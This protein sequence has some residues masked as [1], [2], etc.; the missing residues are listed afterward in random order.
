ML[1]VNAP[2]RLTVL[3]T[4]SVT[5]TENPSPRSNT[6][7]GLMPVVF[8]TTMLVAPISA[9]ETTCVDAITP[10]LPVTAVTCAPVDI[11]VPLNGEPTGGGAPVNPIVSLP[12]AVVSEVVIVP[13]LPAENTVKDGLP[14]DDP[15]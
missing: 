8:T 1:A 7:P 9:F 3:P 4:T 2:P 14:I 13:L 6:K 5:T 11:P 10:P 12:K 15:V